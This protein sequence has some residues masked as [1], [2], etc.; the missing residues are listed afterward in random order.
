[1]CFAVCFAFGV[2][3][4]LVLGLTVFG[5]DFGLVSQGLVFG[6]TIFG[7]DF[8]LVIVCFAFGVATGLDGSSIFTFADGSAF[9]GFSLFLATVWPLREMLEDEFHFMFRDIAQ[10]H[11]SRLAL[12]T[13]NRKQL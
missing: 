10:R 2:T 4:G 3:I 12:E 9:G 13:V 11:W 7:E 6:V 8:G 1:M 5:E